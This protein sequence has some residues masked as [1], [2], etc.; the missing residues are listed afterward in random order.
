MPFLQ[1]DGGGKGSAIARA[2]R[3]SKMGPRSGG[4]QEVKSRSGL[5]GLEA[6]T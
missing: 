4:L 2:L 3:P 5:E 6:I 1:A